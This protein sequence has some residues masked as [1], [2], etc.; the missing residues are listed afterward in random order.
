MSYEGDLQVD[1][2]TVERDLLATSSDSTERELLQKAVDGAVELT[3]SEIGYIHYVNADQNSIELCTWS[4][5]TAQYCTAT[6]DR[7]YDIEKAGIWADT[8]RLR[9]PQIHNSYADAPN[10][11]GLPP[12]HAGLTRHL[13][14]PA[15]DD[16]GVHLLLGVGNAAE[17]YDDSDVE[18]AQ[19][20]VDTAWLATQRL[21]EFQTLRT[22][23]HLLERNQGVAPHVTWEW[24]PFT[25]E[26]V[27]D[28]RTADLIPGFQPGVP[29]WDALTAILDDSSRERLL[30]A[31]DD[32][33]SAD[34]TP[35]QL[36]T[37]R[38]TLLMQ[39][40]WGDRTQ[41][42]GRVLRGTLLDVSVLTAL[43]KANQRATHDA[44]TGLPNRAWLTEELTARL[45]AIG[46]RGSDQF[47]VHFMDLDGFKAINDR[48]GH[49]AGDTVLTQ[50]AHR[51][52]SQ[53]RYGDAVARFGGDEFVLIQHGPV[54]LTNAMTVA[55]R[56][57]AGLAARPITVDGEDITVGI[58]VGVALCT[59]PGVT[60]EDLL[61]RADAALYA[62]K[63]TAE[64]IVV[65][66]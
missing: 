29:A 11:R 18:V 63:R 22:R 14:V 2:L 28:P 12:G 7:H 51:L 48:L 56:M 43:D 59:R 62:A 31:L 64:H 39:G 27:W 60:L 36:R 20:I 40:Y 15:V 9:K 49:L 54:S 24:D 23:M 42:R 4:R 44:L 33:R 45:A 16:K 3:N 50:C 53:V 35:T 38:I 66:W 1:L 65:D 34:L 19:T 30:A 41:G 52:Q 26:V 17:P 21:R 47:A 25:G 46:R 10:R 8:A 55:Q 6:Y 37:P 57:R 5:S 58:S 61:R 32:D 13:G